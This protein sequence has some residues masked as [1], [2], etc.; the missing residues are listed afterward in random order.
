MTGHRIVRMAFGKVE[1][2]C[3]AKAEMKGRPKAE[4]AEILPWYTG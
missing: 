1:P 4:V 2:A 3:V